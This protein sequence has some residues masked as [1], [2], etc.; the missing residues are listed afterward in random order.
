MFDMIPSATIPRH[1]NFAAAL[2]W[3]ANLAIRVFYCDQNSAQNILVSNCG[4]RDE[5]RDHI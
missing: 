5:T 3:A 4:T 2:E 1:N